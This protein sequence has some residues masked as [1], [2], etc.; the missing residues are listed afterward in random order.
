MQAK[1]VLS[2]LE[3]ATVLDVCFRLYISIT[4]TKDAPDIECCLSVISAFP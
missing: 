1:S 2:I 3:H 4:T